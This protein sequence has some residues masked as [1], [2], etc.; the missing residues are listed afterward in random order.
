MRAGGSIVLFGACVSQCFGQTALPSNQPGREM[1]TTMPEPAW[2]WSARGGSEFPGVT[3]TNADDLFH[4]NYYDSYNPDLPRECTA[5]GQPGDTHCAGNF[6]CLLT[7]HSVRDW[8]ILGHGPTGDGYQASIEFRGGLSSRNFSTGAFGYSMGG[9]DIVLE[10]DS[11]GGYVPLWEIDVTVTVNAAMRVDRDPSGTAG[12]RGEVTFSGT[13]GVQG[14]TLGSP[15][16][17]N[18]QFAETTSGLVDDVTM[19]V[20][21][22]RQ[23]TFRGRGDGE[24]IVDPGF[25]FSGYSGCPNMDCIR[26]DGEWQNGDGSMVGFLVGWCDDDG[27]PPF[28]GTQSE[29]GGETVAAYPSPGG[30]DW[31]Q[32]GVDVDVQ[33]RFVGWDCNSN[34][35][36]DA[37]DIADGVIE[38]WDGNGRDDQCDIDAGTLT[39]CNENRIPDIRELAEDPDLDWNMNGIHDSCDIDSGVLTDCDADEIPDER[40]VVDNPDWDW[41]NNGVPDNCDIDSGVLTDCDMDGYPDERLATEDPSLD[42]NRDLVLDA[43]QS[44]PDED[45]DGQ[46]DWCQITD[47]GAPDCNGNFRLDSAEIAVLD[48]LDCNQNG[49]P[50]SCELAAMPSLD[51]DGD[52]ILDD[53]VPRWTP[54]AMSVVLD[55][56]VRTQIGEPTDWW[57]DSIGANGWV[58]MRVRVHLGGSSYQSAFL[59]YN[60]DTGEVGRLYGVPSPSFAMINGFGEVAVVRVA[61]DPDGTRRRVFYWPAG[62]TD[63]VTTLDVVEASSGSDASRSFHESGWLIADW[64]AGHARQ[65]PRLINARTGEIRLLHHFEDYD[66][67]GGTGGMS[68]RRIMKDGRIIGHRWRTGG[69]SPACIHAWAGPFEPIESAYCSAWQCNGYSEVSSSTGI[70]ALWSGQAYAPCGGWREI[71]NRIYDAFGNEYGSRVIDNRGSLTSRADYAI[72]QILDGGQ[73]IASPSTSDGEEI[74]VVWPTLASERYFDARDL[75]T[76]DPQGISDLGSEDIDITGHD[77]NPMISYEGSFVLRQSEQIGVV[78]KISF[79]SP[80]GLDLTADGLADDADLLALARFLAGQGPEPADDADLNRDGSIDEADAQALAWWL[81]ASRAGT[82]PDC[83]GDGTPDL[84]ELAR[85][86]GTLPDAD[87]DLVPDGCVPPGCNLADLV[88]PLGLHDLAD[89]VAFVDGFAAGDTALDFDGSG[90]LDLADIVAFVTAFGAGCP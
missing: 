60:L 37:H 6:P 85:F 15:V 8:N 26:I 43:C 55:E 19:S 33:L 50:D 9:E 61:S 21:Q 68:L 5:G 83:D 52:G 65:A 66:V 38:D 76:G 30:F 18:P 12:A 56:W 11:G 14:D 86:G 81:I 22:S 24:V 80:P 1:K 78:H 53:C 77:Y 47:S 27:T 82:L 48:E 4:E 79:P 70:S 87:N 90:L 2:Q 62:Q 25:R 64:A 45:G 32:H 31:T 84:A 88:P 16:S 42:C 59:R 75:L 58:L 69:G 73:I 36:P 10:I 35:I 54:I 20:S 49:L 71:G 7:R 34:F 89:V 72:D 57:V 41:N 29:C 23:A 13:I 3:F 46:S 63:Y 44:V 40:E 67:V 39:D 74:V 28:C 17:G 51:A